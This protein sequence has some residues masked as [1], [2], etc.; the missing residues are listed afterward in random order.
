VSEESRLLNPNP[1]DCS[2]GRD[3]SRVGA[4]R[5]SGYGS[6]V[7]ISFLVVVIRVTWID[8]LWSR[9]TEVTQETLVSVQDDQVFVFHRRVSVLFA[10]F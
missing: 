3:A 7:E 9:V 10:P 8:L 5:H 6:Q 4:L 2:E 1:H